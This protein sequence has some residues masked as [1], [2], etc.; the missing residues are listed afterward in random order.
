MLR[1][2]QGGVLHLQ[3]RDQ[4]VWSFI[5]I[6]AEWGREREVE[7][8]VW[9]E[10]FFFLRISERRCYGSRRITETTAEHFSAPF[11]KQNFPLI[12]GTTSYCSLNLLVWAFEVDCI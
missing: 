10:L 4:H 12:D 8:E 5:A 7:D 3:A 11:C 9:K 6:R 2:R 1:S